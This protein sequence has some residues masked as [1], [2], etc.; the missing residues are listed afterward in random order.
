VVC[1]QHLAGDT[2]N[3]ALSDLFIAANRDA[4]MGSI[5]DAYLARWGA[6]TGGAPFMHFTDAGPYSQ[7][8]SWGAREYPEQIT[9]PKLAALQRYAAARARR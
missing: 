6:L 1:W 8:G 7:F 4:R 3:A 9:S 2:R 5:Y